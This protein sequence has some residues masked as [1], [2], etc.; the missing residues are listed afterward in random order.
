MGEVLIPD[1]AKS[2]EFEA[3]ITRC[4]CGERGLSWADVHPFGPCPNGRVIPLGLVAYYHK[5]PFKR[6]AVQF[7]IWLR[8]SL[9]LRPDLKERK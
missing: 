5:N 7:C 9:N 3:T 6:W 4:T 1:G 8:D 2:A